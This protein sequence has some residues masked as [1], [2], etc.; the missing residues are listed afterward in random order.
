MIIY[1]IRIKE[2]CIADILNYAKQVCSPFSKTEIHLSVRGPYKRKLPQKSITKYNKEIENRIINING[3]GNFFEDKQL[4]VFLN[5]E[6]DV[7]KKVWS[8]SNYGY[9]PHM[10]LYDGDDSIFARKLYDSLNEMHIKLSFTATSLEEY[11]IKTNAPSFALALSYT[12]QTLEK[13]Q[14][15]FYDLTIL[16]TLSIQER[17][18]IL[19]LCFKAIHNLQYNS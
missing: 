5:C 7:I 2:I 17:I 14:I 10:T 18:N 3:V 8:K 16:K 9:N 6:S 12:P 1:A 11:N 19:T 13:L 4:T 15:P